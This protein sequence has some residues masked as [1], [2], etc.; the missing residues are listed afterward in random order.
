MELEPDQSE[1]VTT[2]VLILVLLIAAK[3]FWD[4]T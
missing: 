1:W 4:E 3:L 2:L